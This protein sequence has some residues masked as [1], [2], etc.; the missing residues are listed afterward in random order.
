[1]IRSVSALAGVFI[2]ATMMADA[3]SP[4]VV[5]LAESAAPRLVTAVASVPSVSAASYAVID[6]TTG[7]ILASKAAEI[8][9]PIAS[10]TKLFT[11]ATLLELDQS[12]TTE[13]TITA[14]DVATEGQAGRLTTGQTLTAR[15]LLFPL[16]LVS[17][18]DA[19][20]ALERAT[21]TTLLAEMNERLKDYGITV[22]DTSGLS[23][24]NQASASALAHYVQFAYEAFPYL[25]DIT[26]LRDYLGTDQGWRN[27]SPVADLSGYRGG[28][29]GYTEAAGRTLVAVFDEE[30]A[31]EGRPIG[32]VLLGSETVRADVLQLRE[33][34]STAVSYQ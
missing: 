12:L 6:L 1:M 15:E 7:E 19:A 33:F 22:A 5:P 13:V 31:G 34:V 21:D 3:T 30:I 10:I 27:N 23:S 11:A 16:L 20:V 24:K 14:K 8:K 17:S 2:V 32:Y 18:N 29:H 4:P 9:R 26:T 25:F 28:K